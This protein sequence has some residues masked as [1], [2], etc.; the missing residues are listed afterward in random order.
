[1][2]LV[3]S[4]LEQQLKSIYKTM[5][6]M[7]V[8]GDEYLASQLGNAIQ[9]YVSTGTLSTTVDVGMGVTPPGPYTGVT[10]GTMS[11]V[12][13]TISGIVLTALKTM[14]NMSAGGD[15]FIAN[16]IGLAINTAFTSAICS[17]TSIGSISSL[18]LGIPVPS[19]VPI[20]GVVIG[21]STIISNTLI[22]AFNTMSNMSEGGDDYLASQMA[23]AVD[24]Y[25][26]SLT[27]I[28]NGTS[29]ATFV[30]KGS[31]S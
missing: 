28:I 29:P 18:P 13:A 24:D 21:V 9:T 12:G 27:I 23:T 25:I 6:N 30:S 8:G 2:S 1:M 14:S 31:L 22:S 5:S 20:T 26:K 7:S 3:K 16:Q 11:I 15:T 17:G 4:T 19:V 10:N